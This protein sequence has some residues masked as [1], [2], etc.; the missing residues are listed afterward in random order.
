MINYLFIIYVL[1]GDEFYILTRFCGLNL[2]E[3]SAFFLTHQCLEYYLKAGI[4]IHM[5]PQKI[6]LLG[7]DLM[8][9]YNKYKGIIPKLDIDEELLAYLNGFKNM[10]YPD[11]HKYHTIGWGTSY[12]ELFTKFFKNLPKEKRNTL[13]VFSLD[14]IDNIVF[15][16]RTSL[17]EGKRLPFIF[18]NERLDY[19]L[20]EKNKY[21]NKEQ[22]DRKSNI[23]LRLA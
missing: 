3:T 1:K 2:L 9:L 10:R 12:K 22:E 21:F 4:S 23:K 7:H 8:K 16:I 5:S 13:A 6:K 11:A 18:R 15:N 19:Y 14:D 20:F 17:P